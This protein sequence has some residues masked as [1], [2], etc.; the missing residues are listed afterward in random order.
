[1][2]GYIILLT[3]LIALTG[4]NNNRMLA[5][6][7]TSQ[8]KVVSPALFQQEQNVADTASKAKKHVAATKTATVKAP[9]KKTHYVKSSDVKKALLAQYQSWKHVRYQL[10]G[11]SRR[12]IDCSGFTQKTFAER[13]HVDLPR[14]TLSQLKAGKTISKKRLRAGDLVFFKIGRH[15]RH[16]GIYI[17]DNRF[18]HASTSQGVIVSQLDDA[19]W[20]RH[21]WKS[22]RVS[23]VQ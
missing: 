5:H 9:A 8:H 3:A 23:G 1:M 7:F 12:G 2:K 4:C 14:D 16:V 19:Y 18:L 22:V 20:Q 21:Y 15:T 10:G 13:F 6:S 11:Q 17:D